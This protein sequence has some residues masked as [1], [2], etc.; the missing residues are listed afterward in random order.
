MTQTT[1]AAGDWLKLFLNATTIANIAIN[2]TSG[3]LTVIE[4]S[5]HT[6]S[7]GLTGTQQTNEAAYG[8][9]ARVAVARTSGGWTITNNVANPVAAITFPAAASGSETETFM[10]M[11]SSHT[12]AGVLYWYGAI[13]PSIV[14]SA[15]VTPSLTTATAITAT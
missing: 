13:S 10:G 5:L 6:S 14:V 15:G 9:Y 7:P 1:A 12:G 2:A 8:S 11:G 4:V 3:P